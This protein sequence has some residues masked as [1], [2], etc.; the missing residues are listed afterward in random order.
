MLKH[1]PGDRFVQQ[2]ANDLLSRLTPERLE[3]VLR[4]LL[5]TGTMLLGGVGQF[6]LVIVFAFYIV[7][8]EGG[9]MEW[10]LAYFKPDTRA[11]CKET[12]DGLQDVIFNYV[13]GQAIISSCVLVVTFTALSLLGVPGAA[14]LALLAAIM[15]VLPVLGFIIS[16]VPAVL[17]AL[18][19][20]LPVALAV[21]AL[22][23]VYHGVENYLLVPRVYGK[24][25]RISAL[26]VLLGFF[27]GMLL[28]GV[29]GAVAALPL[30]AAYPL[31]ERVWLA[32]YLGQ[33]VIRKH[34]E[35][36]EAEFGKPE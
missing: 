7:A 34:E 5:S 36:K 29:P 12:I 14:M 13:V 21:L 31:I 26:G 23:V 20:S 30:V 28:A 19:V 2:T 33:R 3:P 27:T 8:D 17:L 4:P 9:L 32:D 25:L 6:L 35:Q 22:Y 11:K 24:S 18:S 1:L 15:D 16:G 10:F